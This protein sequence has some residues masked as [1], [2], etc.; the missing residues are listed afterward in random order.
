MNKILTAFIIGSSFLAFVM[1]FI[2][3]HSYSGNFNENNCLNNWFN[4]DP[5][6]FYTLFAPFY[7][8]TMSS[9]AIVIHQ[10]NKTSIRNSFLIVSLLSAF[11]TGI[12]ITVCQIYNF[13]NKRLREQYLRLIVYHFIVYNIIIATLYKIIIGE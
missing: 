2:G 1:F 8:G 5:Y 7:L 12:A 3:F 6:F 4:I 10:Y 9:L 13:S 11:L